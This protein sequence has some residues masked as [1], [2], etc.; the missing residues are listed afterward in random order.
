MVSKSSTRQSW[1]SS[2]SL[3]VIWSASIRLPR[4]GPGSSPCAAA[5]CN[6]TS[7][8]GIW[9]YSY[10]IINGDDIHYV[11]TYLIHTRVS[12]FFIMLRGTLFMNRISALFVSW[13]ALWLLP[14][15]VVLTFFRVVKVNWKFGNWSYF[16]RN[17]EKS[18]LTRI[19]GMAVIWVNST[20]MDRL[21]GLTR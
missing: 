11:H 12:G 20:T 17:E 8:H 2:S 4:L 6:F 1:L 19:G 16:F 14:I 3:T 15:A 5:T 18:F 13:V 9:W 7:A 21:N 10:N